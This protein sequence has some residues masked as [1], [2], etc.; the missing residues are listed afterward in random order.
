MHYKNNVTVKSINSLSIVRKSFSLLFH[1]S[2]HRDP[3]IF[4]ELEVN[5]S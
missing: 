4:I 5:L 2:S 1:A 3:K